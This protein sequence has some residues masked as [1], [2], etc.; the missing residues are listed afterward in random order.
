MGF[1]SS[2]CCIS[3]KHIADKD[4]EKRP[5]PRVKPSRYNKHNLPSIVVEDPAPWVTNH[6]RLELRSD[7]TMVMT[8]PPQTPLKSSTSLTSTT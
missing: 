5:R 2:L 7:G 8:P 6:G 1:L 3:S 4:D